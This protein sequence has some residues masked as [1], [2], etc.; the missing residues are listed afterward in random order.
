MCARTVPRLAALGPRTGPRC[1]RPRR[2]ARSPPP[3]RRHAAALPPTDLTLPPE[4]DVLDRYRSEVWPAVASRDVPSFREMLTRLRALEA[5]R[6]ARDDI[7]PVAARLLEHDVELLRRYLDSGPG[8]RS[9][10]ER[11]LSGGDRPAVQRMVS[12]SQ[13]QPGSEGEPK[14]GSRELAERM[15]G[16]CAKG[17]CE[18]NL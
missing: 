2:D 5:L 1:R 3:L 8:R 11:S 7:L 9:E 6:I 13:S 16:P 15:L 18:C 4:A 14:P 10:A 17:A 12:E